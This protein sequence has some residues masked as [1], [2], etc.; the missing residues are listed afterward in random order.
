MLSQPI[1]TVLQQ[2]LDKKTVLS[3]SAAA[4]ITVTVSAIIRHYCTYRRSVTV[5]IIYRMLTLWLSC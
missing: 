1:Q 5:N 3:I 4:A 2:D